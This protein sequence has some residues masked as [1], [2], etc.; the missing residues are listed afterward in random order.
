MIFEV[1]NWM[2][3]GQWSYA[4][5]Y[6]HKLERLLPHLAAAANLSELLPYYPWVDRNC[7]SNICV[8]KL[9]YNYQSLN[10]TL[11]QVRFEQFRTQLRFDQQRERHYCTI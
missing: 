5:E 3:V 9:M 1:H 2:T 10:L 11:H 8:E 6:S 7:S 4:D